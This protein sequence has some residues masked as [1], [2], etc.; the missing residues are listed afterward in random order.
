MNFEEME[1]HDGWTRAD[2]LQEENDAATEEALK[3][4]DPC[5]ACKEHP[6]LQTAVDCKECAI[7]ARDCGSNRWFRWVI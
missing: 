2:I 5:D 1:N 3:G 7:V 6:T 4:F